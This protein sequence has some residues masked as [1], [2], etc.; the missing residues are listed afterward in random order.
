MKK[1]NVSNTRRIIAGGLLAAFGAIVCMAAFVPAAADPHTQSEVVQSLT[2]DCMPNAQQ[3]G[4][5]RSYGHDW[6]DIGLSV[7]WATCNV[8]ATSPEEYGDYFAW[9]EIYSKPTYSMANSKTSEVY[10]EDISGDYRYDAARVN[11]SGKWRMPTMAEIDELYSRCTWTYTTVNGC[12]GCKITGPNGKSIFLPNAGFFYDSSLLAA[13]ESGYYWCSTSYDD[14]EMKDAY[15]FHFSNEKY[16]I[17]W[18]ERR[19]GRSI[20]PVME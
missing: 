2:D 10:I 14:S 11:W 15:Y 4:I 19:F 20:R 13:G 12:K 16:S 3:P 1:E 7:K 5:G 6:V 18:G 17:R 9:A 8:G